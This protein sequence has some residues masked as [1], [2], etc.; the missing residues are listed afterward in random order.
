MDLATGFEERFQT[1]QLTC[2]SKFSSLFLVF[3]TFLDVILCPERLKIGV[4]INLFPFFLFERRHRT[5]M[6]YVPFA[7]IVP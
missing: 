2:P 1:K 7:V 4:V 3:V 5:N 6:I